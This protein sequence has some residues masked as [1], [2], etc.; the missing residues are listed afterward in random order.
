MLGRPSPLRDLLAKERDPDVEF[1]FLQVDDDIVPVAAARQETT[2]PAREPAFARLIFASI[3]FASANRPRA[4]S[5]TISSSRIAGIDTR[6]LPRAKKGV[7]S[8]HSTSSA[9]SQ[10]SKAWMPGFSGGKRRICSSI[11]KPLARVLDRDRCALPL[12][13]AHLDMLIVG[14]ISLDK[15]VATGVADQRRGDA[16]GPAGIQHMQ[17]GT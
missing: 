6:K 13:R 14:L 8:N 1:L 11:A 4:L 10:L 17:H 15:S 2:G 9:R 12:V 7:Q 5:P 3:A 16:D